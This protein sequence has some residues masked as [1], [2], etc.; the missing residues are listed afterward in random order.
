MVTSVIETRLTPPKLRTNI[1][2]VPAHAVADGLI[3][4]QQLNW[5]RVKPKP[6]A[7]LLSEAST[8]FAQLL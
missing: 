2:N 6:I 4:H 8:V 1:Q 3:S 5:L 7:A